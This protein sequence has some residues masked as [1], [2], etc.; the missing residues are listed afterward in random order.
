MVRNGVRASTVPLGEDTFGPVQPLADL[1]HPRAGDVW[2]YIMGVRFD[3]L[4]FEGF[5]RILLRR[6]RVM[7]SP[8]PPRK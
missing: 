5:S 3:C 8:H 4:D 1:E 6:I 7:I 2:I